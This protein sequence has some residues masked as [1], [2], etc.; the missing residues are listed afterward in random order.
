MPAVRF[1]RSVL[2]ASFALLALLP[3]AA[4]AAQP[5]HF[6]ENFAGTEQGEICGVPVTIDFEGVTNFTVFFDNEG[7]VV[8]VQGTG[9]STATFTAENGKSVTVSNAGRSAGTVTE[10]P[11]GTVTFTDTYTGVPERIVDADGNVLVKD[12]GR[13][14]FTTTVD[15]STD[16]PTIVSSGITFVAGPHPEAESDFALFCEV[17]TEALT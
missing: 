16:P 14:V 7:N 12:V 10:N 3:A 13:I 8:R 17:V 5:E 4:V 15:F 11:D 2:V 9:R 1:P 6:H